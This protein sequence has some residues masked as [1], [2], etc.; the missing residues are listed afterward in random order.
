MSCD[1]IKKIKLYIDYDPITAK[2]IQVA[3]T[4]LN[5]LVGGDAF[6]YMLS[7]NVYSDSKFSKRVGIAN[8]INNCYRTINAS[9]V[10]VLNGTSTNIIRLTKNN[11]RIEGTADIEQ[12]YTDADAPVYQIITGATFTNSQINSIMREGKVVKMAWTESAYNP[13]TRCNT[14]KYVKDGKYDC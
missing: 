9:G 4:K 14:I 7:F 8:I 10:P 1:K 6:I 2:P 12:T 3:V 5:T 13:V 11:L